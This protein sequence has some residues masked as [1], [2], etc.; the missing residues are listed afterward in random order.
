MKGK[1]LKES[2]TIVSLF[3]EIADLIKDARQKAQ[4]K[5]NSELVILY[6]NIGRVINSR[7][8]DLDTSSIFKSLMYKAF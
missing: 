2:N 3:D 6:W 5:V 1:I 4:V 7:L 8:P